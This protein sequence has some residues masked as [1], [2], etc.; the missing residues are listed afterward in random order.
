MPTRTPGFTLI[1]ILLVMAVLGML[2]AALFPSVTGARQ[3]PYN[4]AALKCGRA[5]VTFET[6]A[7]LT[8]GRY[9]SDLTDMSRD[10]K[11]ACL[12]TGVQVAPANAQV[13][14]PDATTTQAV[15]T[16]TNTYAFQVF[17][18]RGSG[19][20]LY[21]SPSGAASGDRLGHLH[22]WSPQETP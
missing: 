19:Y 22:R 17:H 5:I 21:T 2:A 16:T 9:V 11:A 10:V 18:P 13:S 20:Y 15:A 3:R 8:L 7:P 6:T 4:T 12:T 14:T 1:E